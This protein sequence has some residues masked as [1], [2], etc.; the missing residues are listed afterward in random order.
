MIKKSDFLIKQLYRKL[1]KFL[2]YKQCYNC[3][4]YIR[5]PKHILISENPKDTYGVKAPFCDKCYHPYD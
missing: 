1:L 3:G 5:K 4:R 2:S